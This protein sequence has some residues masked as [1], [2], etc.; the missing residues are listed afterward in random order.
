[1][2]HAT[3]KHTV[4]LAPGLTLSL[5]RGQRVQIVPATNLPPRTDGVAEYHARPADGRWA[6][7]VER[8]PT[9]TMVVDCLDLEDIE[10]ITPGR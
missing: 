8:G 4:R 1:M 2:T 9:D 5:E 10:Q 6:D 7:G 3:M